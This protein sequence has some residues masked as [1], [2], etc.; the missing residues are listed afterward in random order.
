M[1]TDQIKGL[2]FRVEVQTSSTSGILDL[3]HGKLLSLDPQLSHLAGA[4]SVHAHG[5]C[6]CAASEFGGEQYARMSTGGEEE[7]T[8]ENCEQVSSETPPSL[9]LTFAPD[10]GNPPFLQHWR[11]GNPRRWAPLEPGP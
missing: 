2:I 3:E 9:G 4:V 7:E 11:N 1:D 5:P 6:L 10:D 8:I